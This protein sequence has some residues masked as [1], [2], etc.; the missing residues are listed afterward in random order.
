MK[1]K[2]IRELVVAIC[3]T[4]IVL[5]TATYAWFE[6]SNKLGVANL[7]LMAG[8]TGILEIA[9]DLGT[10]PGEYGDELGL[11]TATGSE[12]MEEMV[13]NP[14]TTK[15]GTTFYSPVYVGNAVVNVKQITEQEKLNTQY[16]YEKTFYLRAGANPNEDEDSIV[17]TEKQ[18][19]D[20]FLV[21]PATSLEYKGTHVYQ[22]PDVK[23]TVVAGD[24]AANALRISFELEDG[25]V[26]IYEPNADISNR[27]NNR[28]EDRVKKDYGNYA[29]VKQ[30]KDGVFID[31]DNGDDSPILFRVEEGKDV[32]VTMRVWIEGTDLDC[33]DSIALDTIVAMFEF[34]SKEAV[35]E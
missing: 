25:T 15:D 7:S 19:Y 24:S 11:D 33:T 4:L 5:S 22:S 10:G 6:K 8:G 21:G 30:T 34:M 9:D 28:A 17:V 35:Y 32:K 12:R 3:I 27:D 18:M 1:K 2:K 29:T 13:L 26:V 23:N 16:V 31:S 20:I 14:V